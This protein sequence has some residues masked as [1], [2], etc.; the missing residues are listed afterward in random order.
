VT[1]V[2]YGSD[3]TRAQVWERGLPLGG[4]FLPLLGEHNLS[5][6]LAAIAV[7]RQVGVD[8]ATIA[9]AMA[10]F[11]G[12]KRRFEVRGTFNGV[13]L[14]DD[15]A[16]HPSELQVTLASAKLRV[17]DQPGQRIVA[18]FQ[19]HRYSRTQA[20]FTEFSQSF[21]DA[22]VVIITDI[23][24]AGEPPQGGITG[25]ALAAA[26]AQHHP[27]VMYQSTLPELTNFLRNF[28]SPGDFALFLG[29]GNLNQVIPE[30]L[31]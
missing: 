6:A 31:A 23:Y 15:Y 10:T 12:A 20:F 13:T 11:A 4:F 22:D 1:D 2:V 28:L 17:Q 18:I 16:H 29:A 8:F 9:A 25:E 27:Q 30:L 26:I 5:N 3:G 21:Q 14:I 7:A 24:S 19:P